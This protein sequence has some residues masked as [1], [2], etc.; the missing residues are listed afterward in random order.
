MLSNLRNDI[1]WFKNNPDISYLD[2]GATSL[3]PKPVIDFIN[4]YCNHLCTN[5][6]NDDSSFAHQ[7]H[8]VIED[9]KNKIAKLLNSDPSSIAFTPGAT[10]SLNA[11]VNF[12]KPFLKDNDEIILTN[13][14]HTSNLLPWFDLVNE[15]KAYCNINIKIEYVEIDIHSDNIKNF[16]DKI[17][18]NTKVI[19]FA[20]EFNLIGC[21][22][23]AIKLSNEVKKI[24]PNIFI[25]V[26]ATQFIVHHKIDLKDSNIDFLSC[27]AHKMLGPTGIG[28]LYINKKFIEK[29]KPHIVGGGMNFEVKRNYYSL[30]EGVT[31][32]EAGTPN[33]MGIYG[34]NKALDY[35]LNSDLEKECARIY[36]L[37][38]YLDQNLTTVNDV[39]IFNSNIEAFNTIFAY[40]GIFSQDLANYLG[41]K[42]IIVRSGLSCAKLANEILKTDHV[43]RA[44]FHFYTNKEDLDKLISAIK[45]FKKEDILNGLL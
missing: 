16:L 43:V 10:Y 32:F 41:T 28:A 14:E 7:A 42:K 25:C 31:K 40:K 2:S 35:Y 34:W 27:S 37:K 26:D 8:L 44:S 23:D 5:P 24:N 29:L 20:N 21:Q 12:L 45:N 13:G 33:V 17:N 39:I 19:C 15:L 38:K 22:I 18:K 9:T 1:E 11:I 3:K 30:I 6:H 36:Q 4:Y